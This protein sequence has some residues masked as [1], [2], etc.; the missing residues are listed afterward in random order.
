M[1]ARLRVLAAYLTFALVPVAEI[2]RAQCT[3]TPLSSG[4]TQATS[5]DQGFYSFAQAQIYWTAVAVR[6][7]A[8]EDWDLGVYQSTAA[9]P[10]CVTGTLGTST[11]VSGVADF[12]IGD[13]NHNT[14]GTYYARAYRYSGTG[15]ATVEWED[16]TDQVFVNGPPVTQNTGST[17]IIRVW[18]LSLTSGTS[19]VFSLSHTGSANVRM[20]LFRNTGG[21]TYWVGRSSAVLSVGGTGCAT[22]TAPSS[23]FYGLVVVNDDGGTDSYTIGVSSQPCGCPSALSNGAPVVD[24]PTD[25]LH[26]FNQ[27]AVYWGAV[28]VQS[29]VDWDIQLATNAG[30]AAAPQCVSNVIASSSLA[31]GVADFV[32]VDFNNSPLGT[33]VVRT[34]EYSGSANANTQW[35]GG[36]Q[37]LHVNDTILDKTRAPGDFIESYDVYL[38]AGKTYRLQYITL[39]GALRAFLFRNP[40]GGPYFAG[41]NDAELAIGTFI[42]GNYTAPTT[43]FYG[44]VVVDDSGGGGEYWLRVLGCT[45][46]VALGD[47]VPVT[48]THGEDYYAFTSSTPR[49]GAIGVSYA[50]TTYRSIATYT[51]ASGGSVPVCFSG[52]LGGS[53]NDMNNVL[54]S[55]FRFT[56]PATYYAHVEDL[57]VGTANLSHVEWNSGDGT[58]VLNDNN[59]ITRSM[60]A[61]N[62]LHV[63]DCPLMAGVTYAMDINWSPTYCCAWVDAY[64]NPG[65]GAYWASIPD[66]V[67]DLTNYP[68]F[69]V[70]K[71]DV[72]G[73]MVMDGDGTSTSYSLRLRGCPPTVPLTSGAPVAADAEGFYSI[74]QSPNYWT[75]V[76]VRSTASD[77]DLEV[78]ASSTGGDY[79][80]C[81]SS[82][83][84]SSSDVGHVDYV[85]GD[86]NNGGNSAGTYYARPFRYSGTTP[87]LAEWDGSADQIVVGAPAVHRVESSGD[88]LECWDVFLEAG[89]TYDIYL[90]HDGAVSA[91]VALFR[92]NNA[93]F[94][95]PR[96]GNSYEASTTGSFTAPATDFYGLVLVNDNGGSGNVDLGVYPTGVL[97]AGDEAPAPA[98]GLVSISPNPGH[99]PVSIRYALHEPTRVTFHVMDMAG[100]KVSSVDA[101]A[102]GVGRWTIDWTATGTDG[103][104]LKA[105]LYFVRME[106]AGR[107]IGTKRIALLD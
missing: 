68:V 47:K 34:H 30:G 105:G 81:F 44:L 90:K 50:N 103:R 52:L 97:A 64:E 53:G 98:S 16:G 104:P 85:V 45:T 4:V 99:G 74:T 1:S 57:E 36:S 9:F 2:A 49:W 106:A 18:D 70:P 28:A 33:Y 10:T 58:I 42:D 62:W 21:G 12:V 95:A 96:S 66:K 20:L 25:Q 87:G 24:V 40:G 84:G 23:G 8:G 73:V 92:S 77:W 13:F 79:G 48:T 35:Y 22:Y 15:N 65:S 88:V 60:D 26:S 7:P 39:S 31:S 17:D 86:F 41:R 75:A 6:P 76:G 27:T 29:S 43:G 46:P 51:S 14:Q 94:W 91:K 71:T 102:R 82:P 56:S 38:E 89:H 83:L 80:V 32:V 11:A 100:R 67:A 78:D 93:P 5:G 63:Y 59:W 54:I 69:T 37:L 61:A 55:D 72:H 101:G 107:L 19:Y 3:V